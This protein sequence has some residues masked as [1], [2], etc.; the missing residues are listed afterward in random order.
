MRTFHLRVFASATVALLL[1]FQASYAGT[2]IKLS[3]SETGPDVQYGGGILST[4]NDGNAGTTGEQD[5]AI[6][7]TDFLSGLG[8]IPNGS[9]TL[10]NAAASGPAQL[11]GGVTVQNF[12]GGN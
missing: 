9:F 1:S 12:V 3:L 5:S 10:H 2:I 8:S 11:V 7:F 4:A 6:L